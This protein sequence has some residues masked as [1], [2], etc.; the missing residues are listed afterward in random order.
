[1]SEETTCYI[2]RLEGQLMAAVELKPADGH[3]TWLINIKLSYHG[4]PAGHTSFNL[5][6][7]SQMEAENVAR[8]IRSNAFIMKEIDEQL[9][10]ESD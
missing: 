8:N 1:M 6:G 5:H 9:W 4:E 10:G 7:Y 2:Q 3:D